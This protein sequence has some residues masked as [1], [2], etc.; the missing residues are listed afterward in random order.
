MTLSLT[1]A[2]REI[3]YQLPP[4]E[5]AMRLAGFAFAHAAGSIAE[6]AG[7]LIP[8]GFV[9]R[10][11]GLRN[12]E[13]IMLRFMHPSPDEIDLAL[14]VSQGRSELSIKLPEYDSTVLVFDGYVRRPQAPEKSDAFIIEINDVAFEAPFKVIQHYQPFGS[15]RFKLLGSPVF[16]QDN[17]AVGPSHEAEMAAL[18]LDGTKSNSHAEKSWAAWRG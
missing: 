9:E 10:R 2:K 4:L 1:T 14:S 3:E 7:P 13:R 18:F 17:C 12:T 6:A 15:G 8:V 5:R 16:L 11:A